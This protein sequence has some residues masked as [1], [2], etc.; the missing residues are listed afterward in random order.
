MIKHRAATYPT[1]D[2]TWYGPSVIV[3]G[4][5][6]INIASVCASVPV[7]WPVITA[8]MDAIFV[9]HEVKITRDER[10]SIDDSGAIELGYSM[11]NETQFR[12][13]SYNHKHSKSKSKSRGHDHDVS[14]I[15]SRTELA[16]AEGKGGH[17]ADNYVRVQVVPQALHSEFSVESQV[18]SQGKG[19]K[20]QKSNRRF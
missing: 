12:N 15:H 1:F 4:L 3:L 6:E 18:T 8:R 10:Y 7:F 20:R 2:P 13:Y 9:T 19:V 11:G 16:A 17:Y 14:S 5:L